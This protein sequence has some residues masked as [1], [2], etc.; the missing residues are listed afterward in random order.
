MKVTK[1]INT[2]NLTVV[3]MV[4]IVAAGG[5]QVVSAATQPVPPASFLR[6]R[7]DSVAQMVNQVKTDHA[8]ASRYCQL[9]NVPSAK[10]VS[11]V[12]KNVVESYVPA[13]KTYRVWC[14]SKTGKLF[15]VSSRLTAGTRVFALRNG[16][17]VMKWA[18]GNPVVSSLPEAPAR[19]HTLARMSAVPTGRAGASP[20]S[21]PSELSLPTPAASVATSV[22][23]ELQSAVPQTRVASSIEQIGSVH[24]STN[25]AASLIPLAGAAALLTSAKGG[26]SSSASVVSKIG[27]L[28][29]AGSSGG[30]SGSVG[31]IGGGRG[32]SIIGGGNGVS[33]ATAEPPVTPEPNSAVTLLLGLLP[34]AGFVVYSRRTSARSLRF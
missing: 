32:G 7:V 8:V 18:C 9:F 25:G 13:T 27:T 10:L 33:P 30:S 23:S 11:Y 17:P 26:S 2:I 21:I 3:L 12:Q 6:F 15:A 24:T 28:G 19:P 14:V 1:A 4:G 31:S 20:I 29:G 22:P 34:L 5:M 16:T